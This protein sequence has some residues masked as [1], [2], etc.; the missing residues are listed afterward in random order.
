MRRKRELSRGAT[1]GV[2]SPNLI[3]QWYDRTSR[4]A[5]N[6]PLLLL[7]AVCQALTLGISW[8]VWNVR[9]SPPLL[10]LIPFPEI[11]FGV[12]LAISLLLIVGWPR[13]GVAIHLA[14]LTL[15]IVADQ[16][17]LQPQVISLAILMLGCLHASLVPMTRWYL[18]AMWL[19]AG[20]HKFLSPEWYGFQSWW[21]L[22]ACGFD[23]DTWHLPF[24]IFVATFETALGVLAIIRPKWAAWPAV[25]LHIGLL[26]L[27]S[28]LVRNFNISVWPWNAATAVAAYWLLGHA[29]VEEPRTGKMV[30]F[31]RG[32]IAMLMIGPA[33]YYVDLVNPHLAFVLYSGNMPR[34]IH[35]RTDSYS[36]IDGWTGLTVPF[37]DSHWLFQKQ[38]RQTAK[39][40][41][42]LHIADP[43]PG[44]GDRYF[45]MQEAGKV[46]ELSR[47]EYWQNGPGN[48][49]TVPPLELEDLNLV[50]QLR[51]GG[52]VFSPRGSEAIT[53]AVSVR[54]A[55]RDAFPLDPALVRGLPNLRELRWDDL[56]INGPALSALEEL[57]QLEILELNR[58]QLPADTFQHLAKLDSLRWLQIEGGELPRVGL[59][60][61]CNRAQLQTLK[62]PHTDFG[63]ADLALIEASSQIGWLELN[64]T[65][66]TSQGVQEMPVLTQCNWLNLADTR[67]DDA[68]LQNLP[69]WPRLEVLNLART[70]VTDGA[71]EALCRLKN[72]QHLD[73][74]GTAIT[75]AGKARLKPALPGLVIVDG[76]N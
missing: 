63:D 7:I 61:F 8:P 66:I 67:I 1:P 68:A 70:K 53:S 22:E 20:L 65:R 43:R 17:R 38:F 34:A 28:P 32:V 60:E 27:L 62:L 54:S 13:L 69:D 56:S 72:C 74:T 71:I 40:G 9:T 73:L 45:V 58:C 75:P 16:H 33:L 14:V 39:P 59:A 24:A 31:E 5:L 19:W 51:R 2:E 26:V 35:V 50:W 21:F 37:P 48:L 57:Y 23:G 6:Y 30:W 18:I 4:S 41:E 44:I 36:R 12:P 42:R 46:V 76:G 55:A 25:A 29:K 52:Y 47:D 49:P 10:P 15:A 11:S 64:G 3:R